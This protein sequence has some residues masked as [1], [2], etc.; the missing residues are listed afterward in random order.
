MSIRQNSAVPLFLDSNFKNFQNSK[1]FAYFIKKRIC[2]NL[3]H[4]YCFSTFIDWNFSFKILFSSFFI[5]NQ[6][7]RFYG[8]FTGTSR[9]CSS[10]NKKVLNEKPRKSRENSWIF[11][12]IWKKK[13]HYFSLDMTINK[14][15]RLLYT[16][17]GLFFLGGDPT[18][19]FN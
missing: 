17:L 11:K 9:N 1:S 6:K 14:P 7:I 18:T 12:N 10:V 19:V 8:E 3:Y 16:C 2:G 15:K 4:F 5:K 13:Q